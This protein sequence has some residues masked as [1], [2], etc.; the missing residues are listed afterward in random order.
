M[1]KGSSKGEGVVQEPS[2]Y[3]RITNTTQHLN[4]AAWRRSISLMRWWPEHNINAL[5]TIH[6]QHIVMEDDITWTGSVLYALTT[7]FLSY[8]ETVQ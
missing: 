3:C 8:K 2:N 1:N 5:G 4:Y 6:L 7:V